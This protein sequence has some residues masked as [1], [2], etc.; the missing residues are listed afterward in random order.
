MLVFHIYKYI[1]FLAV[2][3]DFRAYTNIKLCDYLNGAKK[4][5][6][7]RFRACQVFLPNT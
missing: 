7:V 3:S 5:V 1:C 2:S 4:G 6:F